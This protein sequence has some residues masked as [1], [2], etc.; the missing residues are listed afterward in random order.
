MYKLIFTSAVVASVTA[1]NTNSQTQDPSER[2]I[3]YLDPLIP[4]EVPTQEQIDGVIAY[5]GDNVYCIDLFNQL[6]TIRKQITTLTEE[7]TTIETT[8]NTECKSLIY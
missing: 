7:Y 1:T 4:A 2:D 5:F 3:S 6:I 8:Y